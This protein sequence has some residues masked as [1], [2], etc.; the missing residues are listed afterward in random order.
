MGCACKGGKPQ[1]LNN[2]DSVDHLELAFVAYDELIKDKPDDYV[3][4]DADKKILINTFYS[5]YPNVKN[6][7]DVNHAIQSIK[8]IHK[9][10][11]GKRKKG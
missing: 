2:L 3:Y 9:D 10:Y 6:Q 4:D 11:Y 8:N 5:I 1:V 7:I